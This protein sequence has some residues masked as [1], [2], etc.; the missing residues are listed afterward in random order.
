MVELS[1]ADVERRWAAIRAALWSSL[2]LAAEVVDRRVSHQFAGGEC[3]GTELSR[4]TGEHPTGEHPIGCVVGRPFVVGGEQ[5]TAALTEDERWSRV[6]LRPRLRGLS[7]DERA[8]RRDYWLHVAALEHASIAS[9]A[10]FTARLLELAAPPELIAE[11]LAAS[12]DEFV[13]TRMA[14]ALASAYA[15]RP[16]RPGTLD[17]TRVYEGALERFVDDLV[18]EGCIGE[19]VAV[20]RA[21]AESDRIADPVVK[22]TLTTIAADE[23]RHAAL[24]WKTLRWLLGRGPSERALVIAQVEAQLDAH[25]GIHPLVIRTIARPVWSSIVAGF[26]AE[27]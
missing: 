15:G 24:A 25:A 22:D 18:V 5:R 8:T 2:S 7:E 12:R 19:T 3:L 13:H 14:L 6:R 10:R 21:M 11:A 9:F 16:L 23:T 26:T 27:L 17:V 4:P 20:G 1:A